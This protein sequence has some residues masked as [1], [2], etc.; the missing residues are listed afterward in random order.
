MLL[1]KSLRLIPSRLVKAWLVDWAIE[2]R[3][4]RTF[5]RLFPEGL[6]AFTSRSAD[7]SL[8]YARAIRTI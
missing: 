8:L 3:D 6:A 7:G 2:Y 5:A 1:T 4:E